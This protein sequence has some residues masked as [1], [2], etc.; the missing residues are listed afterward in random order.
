MGKK[1]K[2][3]LKHESNIGKMK[4]GTGK[5]RYEKQQGKIKNMRRMRATRAQGGK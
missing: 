3:M 1:E 5:G 2:R 4:R